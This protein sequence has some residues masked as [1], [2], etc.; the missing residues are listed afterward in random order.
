MACEGEQR[1]FEERF[2]QLRAQVQSEIEAIQADADQDFSDIAAH[3][4]N[5]DLA[6]GIGATAGAAVGTAL[7]GAGG[8][9]AGA[10]IGREIGNLFLVEIYMH[11]E[12]FIF[13]V[14]SVT[15][16]QKKVSFDVPTVTIDD[17]TVSFKIPVT[18][19]QR[20]KGPPKPETVIEWKNVCHKIPF[21][22][23]VC[24]KQ[25]QVTVRW[26]DTWIDV[27]TVEFREVRI[28]AGVPQVTMKPHDITFG[29]PQVGM[30]DIELIV[31]IP[32]VR[33]SYKRDVGRR[34]ASQTAALAQSLQE[35]LMR[36]DAEFRSRVQA[37]VAPLALEMF[38]CH[39]RSIEAQR[40]QAISEFEEEIGKLTGVVSALIAKGV[41]ET[42]AS[43]INAKGLLADAIAKRDA[44]AKPFNDALDEL[45]SA[46]EEAMQNLLSSGQ[47]DQALM[48]TNH[49]AERELI[50]RHI[51][52]FPA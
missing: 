51:E 7:G 8:A 18:V 20:V 21:N 32:A 52:Y 22:G 16:K 43:V 37:E 48:K 33:V 36:K 45:N 39:R 28:T 13:S 26:K 17:Q 5:N 12:R 19:M 47:S 6:Q 15:M 3:D 35:A 10:V 40:T 9:A 42:D 34:T 1:A 11:K 41:P 4:D 50:G 49:E 29:V 24:T 38:A 46:I 2:E 23:K 30:K 27:P 25:P 31:E 14:P 44:A